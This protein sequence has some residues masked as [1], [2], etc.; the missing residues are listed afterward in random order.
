VRSRS[1]AGARVI[2]N[3]ALVTEVTDPA[4]PRLDR[5]SALL[6]ATFPDPNTVLGLDRMQ[7]FL[8]AN[9]GNERRR[10]CVLVAEQGTAV[11]GGTIFSYVF[12]SNCGFSEY[13]VADRDVRGTGLGRSLFEARKALLDAEAA[14]RGQV[15]CHGV[16]IEVDNPERTPAQFAEAEGETA[17]EL[18]ER[19]RLFAHLGFRRVD[20][21]YVQPALAPGKQ[22]IDYMD[23]LFAPWDMASTPDI[24]ADW[25][26]DTVEAIWSAWTPDTFAS[27]LATLRDRVR[28]PQL[29]L[30]D[31]LNGLGSK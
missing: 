23:L 1:D 11:V 25:V 16:F 14:G 10:F 12:R 28:T 4:D 22:A 26:F 18:R 9:P 20:A 29:A 19:V 2:L 17:L 6:N 13:I 7:E 24:P 15:N 5:L 21:P 30:L 8:A 27:H 3:T 31:P